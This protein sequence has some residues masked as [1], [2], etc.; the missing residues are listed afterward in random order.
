MVGVARGMKTRTTTGKLKREAEQ[1]DRDYRESILR[2]E[3]L[4]LQ[5][6]RVMASSAASLRDYAFE[7]SAI[8]K[9]TFGEHIEDLVTAGESRITVSP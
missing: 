4:L 2:C 1:A 3:T 8:L 9:T 5:K 6:E 7:L